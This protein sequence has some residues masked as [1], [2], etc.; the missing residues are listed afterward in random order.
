LKITISKKNFVVFV[1]NITTT[2]NSNNN[3]HKND[4][5][6]TSSNRSYT[7]GDVSTAMETQNIG[8]TTPTSGSNNG[9][10]VYQ[11]QT[12]SQSCFKQ[13]D[14]VAQTTSPNASGVTTVEGKTTTAGGG[15]PKVYVFDKER[16]N[17]IS[18]DFAKFLAE[19]V[20]SGKLAM[21]TITWEK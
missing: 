10:R 18:K 9:K 16:G 4:D 5:Q 15:G 12:V 3:E 7:D 14:D 1:L 17:G 21:H 6:I 20:V 8:N 13:E 2:M 19:M 11:D